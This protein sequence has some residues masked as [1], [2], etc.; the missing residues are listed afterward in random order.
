MTVAYTFTGTVGALGQAGAGTEFVVRRRADYNMSPEAVEVHCVLLGD[1]QTA[2]GG[3][4]FGPPT[5]GLWSRLSYGQ[6]QMPRD[7]RDRRPLRPHGC[8]GRGSGAGR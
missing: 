2:A 7:P 4:S 5:G 8:R 1:R 6:A 3:L